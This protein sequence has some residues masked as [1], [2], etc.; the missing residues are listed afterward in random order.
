MIW[1]LCHAAALF[2][3]IRFPLRARSFTLNK[4]DKYLH[5]FSLLAGLF[6]PVIPIIATIADSAAR[7]NTG[8]HPMGVNISLLATGLGFR[9][10]PGLSICAGGSEVAV[11]LYSI[12]LC[13]V[14]PSMMSL[15]ILVCY[16]IH[17]V[18]AYMYSYIY[19]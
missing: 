2:W 11:Y 14:I 3:K 9:P 19:S 8:L 4:K 6:L 5:L 12:I 15:V 17:K 1:L 10:D 16:Y 7:Y 13:S 18:H